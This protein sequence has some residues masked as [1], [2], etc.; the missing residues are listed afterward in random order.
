MEEAAEAQKAK[1]RVNVYIERERER[2]KGRGVIKYGHAQRHVN[3][4][5]AF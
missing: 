1:L 2:E 5:N 3:V 4:Q